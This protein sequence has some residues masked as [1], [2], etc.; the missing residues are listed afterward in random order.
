[1]TCLR[2]TTLYKVDESADLIKTLVVGQEI[3]GYVRAFDNRGFIWISVSPGVDGRLVRTLT[4]QSKSE[5]D[6]WTERFVIGQPVTATVFSVHDNRLDLSLVGPCAEGAKFWCTV[7]STLPGIGVKVQVTPRD[8]GIIPLT[9]ISDT[10]HK[11]P[12]APF[13]P[14]SLVHCSVVKRED[15]QL[16]LSS[17]KS[18]LSQRWKKAGGGGTRKVTNPV[19]SDTKDVEVG[20]V[21]Y[22][23][24]RSTNPSKGVFISLGHNVTGRV[25]LKNMSDNFLKHWQPM[26]P[27]GKLVRS[28]VMVTEPK[29]ELSM[30][31][32]DLKKARNGEDGSDGDEEGDVQKC[33][34]D[35]L[36]ERLANS[37]SPCAEGAKFWCTVKST[38]PGIGVKVQVTPRDYGII[39]LT[40]ISDT[41]HKDPLAPFEPESLV[42]CSVVK[43]EDRQL[44]L[45]SRKSRLSQR[46][47]KAG[48]GG[49]RKVTNPVIS[50]TKD[51]EVGK[52]VYGFVRS[53]NPSKGVFISLGHN[54]TGR[55]MLKNM[56]DNFLKHWQPMF[57]AGKLVRAVVMVTEPKIE[58]SMKAS[59]LRKARKGEDGSDGDE[60]GDVQKCLDDILME[61]LANS[62]SEQSEQ[63]GDEGD[64][65]DEEDDG[66]KITFTQ[67]EPK[68]TS[69]APKGLSLSAALEEKEGVEEEEE[70]EEKEKEEEVKPLSK[71]A[72]KREAKRRKIEEEE[73][74]RSAERK[75]DTT[76][77][78]TEEDFERLVAASPDSSASWVGFMAYWLGRGNVERARA[79]AKR[80]FDTINYRLESEKLNVWSALF[81]LENSFGTSDS[82][83][84]SCQAAAAVNDPKAVFTRL[85]AVL[86]K[87]HKFEELDEI[88]SSVLLKKHRR[89]RN[90]W[91]GYGTS[92]AGQE[93]RMTEARELLTKALKSLPKHKHVRTISHFAQLEYKHGEPAKGA[94]MFENVLTSYPGR[95]DLW[96]VY[97][98]KTIAQGDHEQTRLLMDRV[99]GLK[100]PAK[101]MKF[102]FKRYIDFEFLFARR[103]LVLALTP[104]FFCQ[105]G[106][107]K[108]LRTPKI[109]LCPVIPGF[110]PKSECKWG[111]SGGGLM[112]VVGSMDVF[113]APTN[114]T[115]ITKILFVGFVCLLF[116]WFCLFIL[117]VLFVGFVSLLVL[118]VLFVYFVGFVC[119]F[120]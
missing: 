116:C 77:A 69:A 52:V 12:L 38:L 83:M 58:L 43:R 108:V 65:E 109:M 76:V 49:T 3:S 16:V 8:Y 103:N 47:K 34:D 48:G 89:S 111:L 24:V 98:D 13:E 101:K 105:F 97:L 95:L 102:F 41:Y 93:G 106:Q 66:P 84:A 119:W 4:S 15:R 57:P 11:D 99:V 91:C 64:E 115:N 18:R 88:Y 45:S 46:W 107:T 36:M 17:R 87:S 28:V 118:L 53:T 27:A 32:S 75:T 55:V 20:K 6:G 90:V 104:L 56:S 40:E 26:F 21:V 71:G 7:K 78:E 29:I 67:P 1:M 63:S 37:E 72:A 86:D 82:L 14:E 74:L 73:K 60:E 51:V 9:E 70:E 25:M 68:L 80:A 79:V 120:C 19:I 42:H 85:A 22:G 96:S 50:D 112:L 30:K 10:Y 35:I 81:N 59:D 94:T 117:L 92:L 110:L 114:K 113:W 44:V 5:I 39:P 23:F 54:V 31:A 61:R 100:L 2:F 62:E 33:L